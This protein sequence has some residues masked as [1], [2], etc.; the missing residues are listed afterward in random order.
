MEQDVFEPLAMSVATVDAAGVP[1]VRTV[2]IALPRRTWA[3]V[4]H[5]AHVCQGAGRS[6]PTPSYWLKLVKSTQAKNKI[7]QWF[8]KELKEDNILKGKEMLA[9][10]ARAKDLRSQI[11]QKPSIW[12]VL[13]KYGFRDWDSVLLQLVMAD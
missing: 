11:I 7:N 1:N 2:L 9:Q 10:Y 8:K 13:R 12:A 3:R 5:R 4:H 6:R